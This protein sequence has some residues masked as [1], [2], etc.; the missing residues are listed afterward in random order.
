MY[1]NTNNKFHTVH[2]HIPMYVS[3]SRKMNFFGGGGG[4][5]TSDLTD[6]H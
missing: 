3:R 4:L 6:S 2:R 5:A 1:V